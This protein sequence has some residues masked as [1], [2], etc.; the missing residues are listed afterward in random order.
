M[1]LRAFNNGLNSTQYTICECGKINACL[2]T[3][4]EVSDVRGIG[5][6]TTRCMISQ[7]YCSENVENDIKIHR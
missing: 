1:F 3:V 6:D 4:Q 2:Y 5:Y 7:L